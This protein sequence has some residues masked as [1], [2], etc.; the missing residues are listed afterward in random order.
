MFKSTTPTASGT[1][2]SLFS[3]ATRRT[4]ANSKTLWTGAMG[5]FYDL[6][7]NTA[8]GEATK[9]DCFAGKV[10]LVINVASK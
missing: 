1:L 6:S 4:Y 5:S 7:A 3:H 2:K 10:V 9:L 8:T